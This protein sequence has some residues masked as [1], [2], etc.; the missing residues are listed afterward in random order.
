MTAYDPL[1][2]PDEEP[3]DPA[4][5]DGERKMTRQLLDETATANIHDHIE[6]VKTAAGL[7]H[8]IRSL[9]AA[10]DAERG[11]GK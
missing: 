9:L 8:R 1:H 10:L 5:V 6:M 2:G 3:P 4:S 7:N 11:E